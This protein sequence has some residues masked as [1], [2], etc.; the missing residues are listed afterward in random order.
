MQQVGIPQKNEIISSC[1]MMDIFE[2]RTGGKAGDVGT[3]VK[4]LTGDRL[5]LLVLSD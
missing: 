3:K 5:D 1:G 2:D 4:I